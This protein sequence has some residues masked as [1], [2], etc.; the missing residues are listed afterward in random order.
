M[1]DIGRW[2]VVDPL[3]EK[4]TRH[5]SYNYAF[6]NPIMFIDPDGM[7]PLTD[8]KLLQ[9][10][11]IQRVNNNDG[12]QNRSDDRLFATDINGNVS[13]VTPV[14]VNKASPESGSIIGDLAKNTLSSPDYSNGISY[15]RTTNASDA[16]SVFSFAAKN[17]NVEWG[18]NAFKVGNGVSYTIL[19][20]HDSGHTPRDFIDQSLSKLLFEIHS[21]KNNDYPTSPVSMRPDNEW[22]DYDVL[23]DIDSNFK[24]GSYPKHYMLYAPKSGNGHLWQYD[25]TNKSGPIKFYPG[26]KSNKNPLII[27]NKNPLNINTLR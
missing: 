22:G 18:L 23:N 11:Q 15:G 13:N 27:N 21:H 9:N 7:A 26:N 2:G 6:N 16:A 25:N 4:M 3:A 14:T 8:Y 5:S 24:S 12:S 1:P 20:G 19:T 10:G 17:S